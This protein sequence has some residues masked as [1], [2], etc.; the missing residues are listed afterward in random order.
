MTSASRIPRRSMLGMGAAAATAGAGLLAAPAAHAAPA[1]RT[2]ALA[3]DTTSILRNPLT[4]WV[5][6]GTGSPSADYWTTYDALEIEGRDEPVRVADHAQTLYMRLSWTVLN[7]EEGVYGWD[8]HEGLRSMIQGARERDLR[9]AFRVV[10]D[11]RDKSTDFTPAWVRAAGA[12]GYETQTGSRTVWTPYPDDPV[13]RSSYETFLEAFAARFDDPDEV[14]FIDAY[15]LGKW[16]E[17][18]SMRYLD[19]ANRADVFHWNI[20]L[21]HRLFEHV[22]LAINYHRMIGAAG[23]WGPAD[24]DSRGLLEY[25]F[26]KGCMLRHDAF[27]MSVY[28]G[29]WERDLAAEWIG[30]RP[31][32]FEGGWVTKQHDFS[33]DPRGYETVEDVRRGEYE[34]A[35]EAHVNML[36]FRMGETESW[37]RDV[38]DLVADFESQGGYRLQLEQV[39]LPPAERTGS[40][41][42]RHRWTNLGWGMFPNDLP[43]WGHRYRVAFALLDAADHRVLRT[44]VDGEAEPS[45]WL[46]GDH[47]D[48]DL[49]VTL[50]PGAGERR[51][52][53]VAIVDTTKDGAPAIAIAS[54]GEVTDDGWLLLTGN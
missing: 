18:H 11:S 13:F 45:D 52:W 35:V 16:G 31:I 32:V 14:A 44:Y 27:G 33:V 41:T 17:G 20:D 2:L 43:Q 42:I 12:E 9:L 40:C 50:E 4:G 36:D 48:H 38:P 25:A 49:A 15:G 5:L 10:V 51:V 7:P 19:P 6:Y 30:R 3:A 53:A 28:Y 46:R 47:A 39:V 54:Q 23:D 37:F 24:P 26:E 1:G 29:Q 8:V 34:D 22:P 21:Y